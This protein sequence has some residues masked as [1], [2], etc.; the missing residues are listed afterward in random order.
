MEKEQVLSKV[1][2]IVATQLGI[3]ESQVNASSSFLD[4]LGA[5]SL[6]QVEIV[7]SIEE[8]FS[9]EIPD[10]VAETIKKVEDAVDYII[11]Q[12]DKS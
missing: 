3:E 8:A 2:G 4:D 9:V 12:S 10:N 7:M 1:V 5:D 11:E 6:D